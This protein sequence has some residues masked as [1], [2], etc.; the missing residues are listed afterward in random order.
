MILLDNESINGN[1]LQPFLLE[2]LQAFDAGLGDMIILSESSVV[3][4]GTY[5]Q[6]VCRFQPFENGIEG[7]LG[8]FHARIKI[9]DDLVAVRVLV[10]DGGKHANFQESALQLSVHTIPP[11]TKYIVTRSI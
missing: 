10:F 8:S 4:G 6:H 9:F 7:G 5:R 1:H 11:S 3:F 2:I